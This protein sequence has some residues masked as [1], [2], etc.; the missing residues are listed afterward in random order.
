MLVELHDEFERSAALPTGHHLFEG[1]PRELLGW[2]RLD[3]RHAGLAILAHLVILRLFQGSLGSA[4]DGRVNVCQERKWSHGPWARL[5][6][7][8]RLLDDA[9]PLLAATRRV[10]IVVVTVIV[11]HR[12]FSRAVVWSGAIKK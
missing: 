10:H 3:D 12:G 1:R 8:L 6:L 4:S 11:V 9:L 5:S 7:V 2:G